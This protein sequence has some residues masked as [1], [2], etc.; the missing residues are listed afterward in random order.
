[1]LWVLPFLNIWGW[2]NEGLS[3]ELYSGRSY[4]PHMRF[5]YTEVNHTPEYLIPYTFKQGDTVFINTYNWA[6]HEFNTPPNSDY[7]V[8]KKVQE[9]TLPYLQR[10]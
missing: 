4:T 6:M 3:F 1:M 5:H 7:K 9:A 10:K 8:I 2:Y